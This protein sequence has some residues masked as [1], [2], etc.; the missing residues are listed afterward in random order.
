MFN[1]QCLITYTIDYLHSHTVL[2]T[3]QCTLTVQYMYI[4]S[5]YVCFALYIVYIPHTYVYHILCIY[6]M[7]GSCIICICNHHVLSWSS[8]AP[9]SIPLRIFAYRV[10][11]ANMV[12]IQYITESH[13]IM[14]CRP[15]AD[16]HPCRC[17]CCVHTIGEE[18]WLLKICV[19]FCSSD[20]IIRMLY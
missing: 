4:N 19:F 10:C 15:C 6:R 13:L 1:S 16:S 5:Q 20:M 17:H 9:T 12:S 7:H 3:V 2:Y 14:L 18:E 11:T 8:P